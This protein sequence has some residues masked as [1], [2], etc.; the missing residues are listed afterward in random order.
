MAFAEVG[1][2]AEG[3]PGSPQ[4]EG[5]DCLVSAECEAGELGPCPA[6]SDKPL[7]RKGVPSSKAPGVSWR[8]WQ[9]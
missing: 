5:R 8:A 1:K 7:C 9:A 3:K 2:S 4:G 6:F